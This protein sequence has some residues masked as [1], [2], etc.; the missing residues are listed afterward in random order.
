MVRFQRLFEAENDL[1]LDYDPV[2]VYIHVL[3]GS[4]RTPYS[5]TLCAPAEPDVE[6][7]GGS[8]AE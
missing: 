6:A 4:R 2:V 7:P 3:P 5:A 8:G 1:R